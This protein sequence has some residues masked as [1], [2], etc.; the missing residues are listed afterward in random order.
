M[1][2]LVLAGTMLAGSWALACGHHGSHGHGGNEV[3]FHVGHLALDFHFGIRPE[4]CNEVIVAQAEPVYEEQYQPAPMVEAPMPPI[5]VAPPPPV[6]IE[7]EFCAPPMIEAPAPVYVAP[8]RV[9]LAPPRVVVAVA[10]PT[11]AAAVVAE[12]LHPGPSLL[13]LKYMPGVS[14]SVAINESGDLGVQLGNFGFSQSAGI[15]FRLGRYFALRTDGELRPNGGRSLDVI[16]A[17]LSLFPNSIVRPYGSA[18]LSLSDTPA[19]P[20]QILVGLMGA[21]GLDISIGRHFF[22]EAEVRYRRLPSSCCTE[23]SQITAL[24]GAGVAFF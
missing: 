3:S 15:E 6:Y 19:R 22:I 10:A 24:V 17:K 11:V 2:K 18:S 5:Y 1:N 21:G 4:P 9:Y 8:P 13:A 12:E 7:P 23:E 16:G 14:S 20:G